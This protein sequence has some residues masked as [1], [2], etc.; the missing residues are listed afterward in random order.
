MDIALK[1]GHM[2]QPIVQLDLRDHVRLVPILRREPAFAHHPLRGKIHDTLWFA[3]IEEI[4][5]RIQ[6]GIEI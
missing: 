6:I 5:N 1:K 4:T 2:A 3:V